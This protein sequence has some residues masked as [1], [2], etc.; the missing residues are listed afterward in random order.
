MGLLADLYI[1]P[2]NE[3]VKYDTAPDEFPERVEYKGFTELEL[4]ILWSII[5]G[6]KWDVAMMNDFPCLLQTDGGERAIHKV[7]SLMAQ[8]LAAL[9]PDQIT[10]AASS[11]AAS[12]EINGDPED[13][14]PIV[15]DL[16]R[17]AREAGQ[18][19]RNVYLWN[20]V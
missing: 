15:D 1:S 9:S 8:E 4:S 19:S 16:A 7:P 20:C 11:W 18:T 17:L 5:R 2:G 14:R 3:A 6:I 13:I 10:S 12:E